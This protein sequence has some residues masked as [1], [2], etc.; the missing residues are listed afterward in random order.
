MAQ[1]RILR[2]WILVTGQN[3][4]R[5]NLRVFYFRDTEGLFLWRQKGTLNSPVWAGDKDE[6]EDK[7]RNCLILFYLVF[8]FVP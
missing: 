8:V 2:L 6:L 5:I 4:G 1:D 3:L 7:L